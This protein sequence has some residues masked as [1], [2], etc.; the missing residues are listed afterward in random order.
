MELI[1][2]EIQGISIPKCQFLDNGLII[3]PSTTYE[4]WIRIGVFLDKVEGVSY[5]WRGDWLNFGEHSYED[6]SQVFDPENEVSRESLRKAKSITARIP[7]L[8]RRNDINPSFYEEIVSLEEEEQE[9]MMDLIEEKHLTREEV[10]CEVKELKMN[11]LENDLDDRKIT[12]YGENI[13]FLSTKWQD[14][15]E[16]SYKIIEGEIYPTLKRGSWFFHEDGREFSLR[17]YAQVQDFP[18]EFKFVGTYENI[19]DQIGNAVSPKMARYMG[20]KLEGKTIGDLFAGCGGL[21]CGLESLGK[22]AIWAIERNDKYARTYQVNHP[23]AKVLTRD[24]KKVDPSKLS[25]VDIIVGG[26]PC[27]GFSLSGLR[28]RDDPR[29]ELY[30]EFLRFVDELK[31]KE[32]LME[33]VP[34]IQD[35]KDQIIEDFEKIGYKIETYLI[36]GEEIGMKQKRH[37]F[38]FL[39]RI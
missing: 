2:R 17:E 20:E 32:F 14:S 21:S 27:Q 5:L 22:K 31:P 13:Y 4:E 25:R 9:R 8:R 39:G 38:F 3:D 35:I 6:W 1:K 15:R 34:Q 36:K 37:R 33:N 19:K 24:L 16:D 28:L 12:P 29:N 10:R 30:K 23:N 11:K 18:N 7:L 26:P